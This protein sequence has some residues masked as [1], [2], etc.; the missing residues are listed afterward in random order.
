MQLQ[1]GILA[2]LLAKVS[3]DSVRRRSCGPRCEC[4]RGYCRRAHVERRLS[5]ARSINFEELR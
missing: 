5:L 2:W 4:R 3:R 1:N